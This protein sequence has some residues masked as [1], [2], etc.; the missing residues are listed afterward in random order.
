[1]GHRL[2]GSRNPLD[3][4]PTARR[5]SARKPVQTVSEPTVGTSLFSL[6]PTVAGD[7]F[8]LSTATVSLRGNAAAHSSSFAWALA[9]SF[10]VL[11]VSVTQPRG[12]E[13]RSFLSCQAMLLLRIVRHSAQRQSPKSLPTTVTN[14]VGTFR[15]I[16]S[17]TSGN[18]ETDSEMIQC[19]RAAPRPVNHDCLTRNRGRNRLT[20]V[21]VSVRE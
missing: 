6:L 7:A 10:L 12:A 15:L 18:I 8:K 14:A 13:F 11:R 3:N 16:A 19:L 9:T 20:C 1:M 4:A 2:P 5:Q 17:V 21:S